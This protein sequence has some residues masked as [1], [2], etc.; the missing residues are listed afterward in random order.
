VAELN[1]ELLGGTTSVSSASA[2]SCRCLHCIPRGIRRFHRSWR[3]CHQL[4]V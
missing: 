2:A 1:A 4:S 3:L